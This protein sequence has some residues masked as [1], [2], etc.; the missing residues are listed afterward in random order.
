M[1]ACESVGYHLISSP[2]DF[3]LNVALFRCCRCLVLLK[4]PVQTCSTMH[5]GWRAVSLRWAEE[6]GG[7]VR[8][9]RRRR[10]TL[11]GGPFEDQ[12]EA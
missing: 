8:I 11:A 5:P 7:P 6:A 2:T 1:N 12:G 10:R 3:D 4:P 9:H